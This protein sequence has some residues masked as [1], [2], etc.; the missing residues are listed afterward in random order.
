MHQGDMLVLN[1]DI[2]AC[3]DTAR[4][5]YPT[6]EARLLATMRASRHNS[7]AHDESNQMRA[8]IA[9]V[10]SALDPDGADYARLTWTSKTMEH[11]A[12]Y[13]GALS[14]GV[15]V[16]FEQLKEQNDAFDAERGDWD[17]LDLR[18]L[19]RR[20]GQPAPVQHCATC[21]CGDGQ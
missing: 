20:S 4:Q 14:S 10:A 7:M 8:A 2:A 17:D 19:W 21:T 1:L 16:D 9:A 5:E 12:R 6:L 3:Q 18:A 13:L 15:A 11:G